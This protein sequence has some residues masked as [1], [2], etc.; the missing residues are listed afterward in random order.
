MSTT[1][2]HGALTTA[3]YAQD[4]IPSDHDFVI[5]THIDTGSNLNIVI[6]PKILHNFQ[7]TK[8][9]M[10]GQVSGDKKAVHGIRE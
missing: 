5:W 6:D 2:G 4:L 7:K 10:L 3:E 9:T 8:H 1:I